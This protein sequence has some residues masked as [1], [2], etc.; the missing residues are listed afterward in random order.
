MMSS[1]LAPIAKQ[2]GKFLRLLS[3][4][5][6][7]EVVDSVRAL[8]RTLK[9]AGLD[10]HA[11]ADT[12]ETKTW[13][14]DEAKEMYSRGIEKGRAE[15]ESRQPATF[16]SVNGNGGTE[17]DWPMIAEACLKHRPHKSETETTFCEDMQRRCECG[18][19]PTPKQAAWL[20]KIYARR[21]T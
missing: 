19:E 1:E 21:P 16:H 6:D 7:G 18:G 10:I 13:S 12:V 17:P 14:D 3:S 5:Q 9:S 15:A 11:L 4:D 8:M 20:R 2:L